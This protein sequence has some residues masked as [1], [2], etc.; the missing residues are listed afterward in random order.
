MAP[1][2][3]HSHHIVPIKT[4]LFVFLGLLVLTF[5]TVA[6]AQVHLGKWNTVVAMLIATVK[7]LL[8]MAF[9]MHLKYSG[10]LNRLIIGLGFFF[11]L[12]LYIFCF[13]DIFF[14]VSQSNPL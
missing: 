2:N 12:V 14:R 10:Q 5:I 8:V 3:Q 11:L 6:V 9:F 1:V 7:A 4:Y 13:A